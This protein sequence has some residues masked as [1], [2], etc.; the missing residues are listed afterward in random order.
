[1]WRLWLG[2]RRERNCE[3]GIEWLLWFGFEREGVVGLL[4]A[5]EGKRKMKG[6][7]RLASVN[8]E[9]EACGR[10]CSLWFFC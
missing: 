6:E 4:S 7:G 10:P 3:R 2:E 1:M 5:A 8:R 9:K